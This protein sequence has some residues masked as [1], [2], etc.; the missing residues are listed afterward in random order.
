MSGINAKRPFEDDGAAAAASAPKRLNERQEH[1]L[2]S[3]RHP[4]TFAASDY[5]FTG[6]RP[7]RLSDLALEKTLL[8]P[9]YQERAT[10]Q[11]LFYPYLDELAETRNWDW[12]DEAK[13]KRLKIVAISFRHQCQGINRRDYL[14]P[15]IEDIFVQ[16]LIDQTPIK[17]T[18]WRCLSDD[19]TITDD[20]RYKIILES[21][22]EQDPTLDE[23]FMHS[24]K[25]FVH[26][27]KYRDHLINS[28]KLDLTL[29]G[30]HGTTY[31]I[32]AIKSGHDEAAIALIRNKNINLNEVDQFNRSALICSVLYG[33]KDVLRELLKWPLDFSISESLTN[34]TALEF[35]DRGD[36]S[37]YWMISAAE[38][39]QEQR[40]LEAT[41]PEPLEEI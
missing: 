2:S 20:W 32:E 16:G 19:V 37:M 31:L 10:F 26:L 30:Q 28:E 22:F 18:L 15:L 36:R 34:Q 21:L 4:L 9:Q 7:R 23:D 5:D 24:Y 29:R 25:A 40:E 1:F 27:P 11:E 8:Q 6:V 41:G 12:I 17:E 14:N 38:N 13:L 3:T 35:S 39:A 33:R